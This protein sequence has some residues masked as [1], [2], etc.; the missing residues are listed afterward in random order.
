LER[1]I[2]Q[3]HIRGAA[4]WECAI[5]SKTGLLG[6]LRRLRAKLAFIMTPSNPRVALLPRMKP[7][8]WRTN[9]TKPIGKCP[10]PT[11]QSSLRASSVRRFLQLGVVFA[12]LLAFVFSEAWGEY[13]EAAQAVDLEVSAM[14]GVAMISATL[15]PRRPTQS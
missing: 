2:L 14:H 5:A 7:V 12:V 11:H 8:T 15:G 6:D 1:K 13:N 4:P 9:G 10:T 3:T